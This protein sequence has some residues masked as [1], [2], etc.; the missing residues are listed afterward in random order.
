MISALD[1][2]LA[3]LPPV[4]LLGVV[5]ASVLLA[6]AYL[7]TACLKHGSAATRHFVW[8]LA[9]AGALA[10]PL[11]DSLPGLVKVTMPSWPES[12]SLVGPSADRAHPERAV[13]PTSASIPAFSGTRAPAEP[14][15]ARLGLDGWLAALWLLGTA[16]VLAWSAAGYWLLGRLARRSGPLREPGWRLAVE[17]AARHLGVLRAVEL[18]VS[19]RVGS[20]LVCGLL[21]PVVVVPVE[22]E[23]WPEERRR[24][25]ALHELAHVARGDVRA[26]LLAVLACSLYWFHPAVWLAARR[27]RAESERACDERV[28]AIGGEPAEYATH[29]LDVVRTARRLR[30]TGSV[31]IAMARRSTLE[32]RILSLLDGRRRRRGLSPR[33]RA[34]AAIAG[35]LVV[36][37]L[38]GVRPVARASEDLEGASIPYNG[39]LDMAPGGTLALRLGAGGSVVI[40]GW[41]DDRVEVEG[42]L[43]GADRREVEVTLERHGDRAVLRA[44]PRQERST[45]STSNHFEIHVPRRFDVDLRSAGGEVTIEDLEGAVRGSTG[46]GEIRLAHLRGTVHLSTGGGDVRVSDSEVDGSVGT[47]GGKVRIVRVRGDLSGHSGSG[48]IL[49]EDVQSGWKD[50][51]S[52][53]DEY[54]SGTGPIEVRRAGGSIHIPSAPHGGRAITGGGSVE[55]GRSGGIVRAHTGGGHLELGP[56]EGSLEASTGAGGA[57]VVL[58]GADES[59]TVEITSGHGTVVLEV[60]EGLGVTYELETAYTRTSRPARIRSD[61]SLELDPVSGWDDREGTPRRYVRAHG[62]VGSGRVRVVV[63]TV[64]GDIEVRRGGG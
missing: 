33:G 63:K 48:P 23:R 39:T 14:R 3:A 7:V 46:G 55:I 29:L 38:A 1:R 57:H 13:A 61:V 21:R 58:G 8:L 35:S 2:A 5:Q 19:E 30:L 6:S 43:A 42:R 47:G 20:P 51:H 36:I 45:F 44:D 52:P 10:L 17:Q 32:G 31:A 15:R 22:A 62:A 64:N 27:L 40:R 53:E 60:P 34:A 49:R 56:V 25:V 11:L 59:R 4:A 54:D 26:Q 12:R 37:A 41:S 18:R 16:C 24:V 28:V 9:L 50:E